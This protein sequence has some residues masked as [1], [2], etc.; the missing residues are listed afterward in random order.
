MPVRYVPDTPF[1]PEVEE[2]TRYASEVAWKS[3][4][5]CASA[6]VA[7]NRAEWARE[8]LALRI[9]ET[10]QLGERDPDKLCK[11]ALAF[12]RQSIRGHESDCPVEPPIS[13]EQPPTMRALLRFGNG[14]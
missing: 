10:A 11:D 6:F 2:V 12:L 4:E 3:L 14:S 13:S 8:V 9:V 7:L 1:K 5:D